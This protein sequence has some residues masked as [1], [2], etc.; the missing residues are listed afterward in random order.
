M[1]DQETC[2]DGLEE[3]GSTVLDE[4]R[5]RLS[6]SREFMSNSLAI[7]AQ[8]SAILDKFEMA[9]SETVRRTCR[10][11]GTGSS[12]RGAGLETWATAG[13]STWTLRYIS[14]IVI[15][16]KN[17]GQHKLCGTRARSMRAVEALCRP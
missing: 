7:C 17:M 3:M 5:D 15:S 12:T 10:T 2:L 9:L 8:M 4:V 14:G 1:T 11:C 16:P 13:L 6:R